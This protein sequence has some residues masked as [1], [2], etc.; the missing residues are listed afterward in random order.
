M[1]TETR[2]E[3]GPTAASFNSSDKG[4]QM[5]LSKRLSIIGLMLAVC[6][7]SSAALAGYTVSIPVAVEPN[8]SASGSINGARY[9]SDTVEFIGCETYATAGGTALVACWA[10]SSASQ[11]L[12]CESTD[13][14]LV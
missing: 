14:N 8:V 9:S 12:Y 6:T 2:I 13:P 10:D 5:L 4:F 7:V 1:K 11:Y 3:A